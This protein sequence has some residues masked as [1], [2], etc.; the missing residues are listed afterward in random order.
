MSASLIGRLGSSVFRPST[1][2]VSMSRAG[3][4]FTSESAPGPLYGVFFV[5]EL[6]RAAKL[7]FSRD[8]PLDRRYLGCCSVFSLAASSARLAIHVS[9]SGVPRCAVLKGIAFVKSSNPFKTGRVHR[10]NANDAASGV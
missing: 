7:S 9:Y 10:R 2:T 6:A 1:T 5:K 3:S 4:C 8:Q